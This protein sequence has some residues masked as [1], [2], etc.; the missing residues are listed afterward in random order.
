MTAPE[1][2]LTEDRGAVRILT[3]N[4]PEKQGITASIWVALT[5]LIRLLWMPTCSTVKIYRKF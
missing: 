4:R 3:M 1:V 5:G 2:L